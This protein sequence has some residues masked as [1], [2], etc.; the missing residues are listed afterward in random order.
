MNRSIMVTAMATMKTMAEKITMEMVP[1][2]PYNEQR[3]AGIAEL[4]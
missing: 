3:E 1:I 2:I 4:P